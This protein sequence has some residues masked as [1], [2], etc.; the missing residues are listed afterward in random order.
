MVLAP[1]LLA[2]THLPAKTLICSSWCF[3]IYGAEWLF[4]F[5]VSKLFE[6]VDTVFIVL[7]KRPL[8]FLHY[9]HHIVTLGFCWVS[10]QVTND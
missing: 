9:Y 8:M 6:F 5:N 1:A 3:G 10:N 2:P 4:F 7:R